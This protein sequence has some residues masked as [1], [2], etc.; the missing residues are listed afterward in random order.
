MAQ[1]SPVLEMGRESGVEA[2]RFRAHGR[3]VT[4]CGA[5]I[6][7]E[8]GVFDNGVL[9]SKSKLEQGIDFGPEVLRA[10]NGKRVLAIWLAAA[11]GADG[12]PGW[13][14]LSVGEMRIE[15][16]KKQGWRD[17]T[18]FS[19][20]LMEAAKGRVAISQMKALELKALLGLLAQKP[21]LWVNAEKAFRTTVLS[22]APVAAEIGATDAS[23]SAAAAAPA[24]GSP[25]VLA[26]AEGG[27]PPATLRSFSRDVT[28]VGVLLQDG[29]AVWDNGVL[30]GKSKAEQGVTFG[31]EPL[32]AMQ[33]K[34]VCA[35][36]LA[37]TRQEDG[38]P[39]WFGATVAEMRIDAAK[40]DGFK[41][42]AAG[43][44]K[45]NDAA[46]G[47]VEVWRLKPEE[48][49]ALGDLVRAKSDLWESAFENFRAALS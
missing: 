20:K 10:M 1:Q 17:V 3:A 11:N 21:D 30:T 22:I 6:D 28:I 19:V 41:D 49:K 12:K 14:G 46:R 9:E 18:A 23:R 29:T 5:T 24:T 35:I 26:G 45:L 27:F 37:A 40:K 31:A 39:G 47:R 34:R 33:G 8:T 15:A 2:I 43:S 7:G 13:I 38:K 48:R 16:A 36:F 25:P 32:R 42:L 44:M 4:V